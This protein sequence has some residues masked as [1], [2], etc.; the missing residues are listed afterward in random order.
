MRMLVALLLVSSAAFAQ[1]DPVSRSWNQPVE[2][3]R[4]AGNLYYV[5]ASDVTSYLIT[6]PKGHIVLDGGFAETAPMILANIRKLGFR[7][8][9]VRILLSSHAHE[10]HAGGLAELKR[11]TGAKLYASRRDI[12]LLARGGRDDPQFGDRFSFPPVTADHAFDDGFRLTLGGTTLVARVTPGHTPGCTTWTMRASG[13]K[14]TY[15]VVFVGSPTVPPQYRLK[16]NPNYPDAV[17]D[18]RRQ[19]RI[20]RSLRCDIFLA[21]HGS[22][23]GLTAKVAGKRS[24]IDPI[25]YRTFVTDMERRFEE[26]LARE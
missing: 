26:H 20:L 25:R 11:V 10:D 6:T 22:F 7:V 3:V 14:R 4:I 9:D 2:P 24:F 18:Y 8:E 15:D 5:G 17:A 12:P 21:A 19:F 16:N 1:K 23:F 13:G